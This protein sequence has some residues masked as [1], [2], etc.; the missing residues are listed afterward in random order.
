MYPYETLLVEFDRG[1]SVVTLNRPAARNSM[2]RRMSYEL[3]HA[4]CT[5]DEDDAVRAIVITGAGNTFCAGTDLSGGTNLNSDEAEPIDGRPPMGELEL[6]TFST[7]LIAAINGAAVGLGITYPMQW[8]IRV[9]ARDAKIGFVFNRRGLLPEA[10]ALWLLP[11]LVGLSRAMDLLI[12]GRMFT[13]AE[14]ETMGLVTKAVD[15]PD[16]LPTAVAIARDIADNTAP[17][18]VALT[19]KMLYQFMETG[20]RRAARAEERDLFQW[21]LQQPDAAEGIASFVERRPPRWTMS[22]R[23]DMPEGHRR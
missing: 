15:T 14:A 23:R 4:L 17:V 5:M 18:S 12:T 13:G 1:V 9:A 20:D 8:D 16:V 21:A 3:S 7:P 11:R 22:K 2:N 10:N 6:W 19:K